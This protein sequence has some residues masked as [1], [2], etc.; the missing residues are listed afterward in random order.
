MYIVT[1][2]LNTTLTIRYTVTL[3]FIIILQVRPTHSPLNIVSLT[4]LHEHNNECLLRFRVE[5]DFR[6]PSRHERYIKKITPP[7][8]S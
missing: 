8:I 3:K 4:Q 7:R 1:R 2:Q 6:V 5:T